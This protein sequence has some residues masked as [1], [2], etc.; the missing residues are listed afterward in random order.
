M[1]PISLEAGKLRHLISILQV[2][3]AQDSFGGVSTDQA[4]ETIYARVWANV[5]TLTGR[6]LYAAQQK[7]SQ[8]TH[9]ITMRYMPGIVARMNIGFGTR[10][11]QIQAVENPD[12]RPH[13]LILLCIERDNSALET[14]PTP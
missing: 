14:P 11:F 7:V 10:L 6:E 8:V 13:V 3:P 12:E 4:T 5:E 9:R 1:A 2:A